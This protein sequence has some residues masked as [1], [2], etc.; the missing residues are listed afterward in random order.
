MRIKTRKR[1]NFQ[2]DVVKG[3][4]RT[5]CV[6]EKKKNYVPPRRVRRCRSVRVP[7]ELLILSRDQN[8]FI[9]VRFFFFL[10]SVRQ[11]LV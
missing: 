3:I 1:Q 7:V 9:R 6:Y 5:T 10:R 11:T 8:V 2:T 4:I